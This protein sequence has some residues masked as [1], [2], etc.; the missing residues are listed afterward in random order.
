[1]KLSIWSCD[2]TDFLIMPGIRILWTG[3]DTL[4][5][6]QASYFEFLDTT[7]RGAWRQRNTEQHA[8]RSV[9]SKNYKFTNENVQNN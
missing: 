2:S 5:S 1:M 7:D 9:V 3:A 6:M 4:N 8:P